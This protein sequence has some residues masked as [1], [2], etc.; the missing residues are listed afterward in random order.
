MLLAEKKKQKNISEYIIFMYQTEDLVRVYNF[1]I[2]L[3]KRY[4]INHFPVSDEEKKKNLDWYQEILIRMEYEGIVSKG[5]LEE[6]QNV[7][8]QLSFLS[9]RLL[10]EDSEYQKVYAPAKKYIDEQIEKYKGEDVNDIE[11]CLN[12]IYGYLLMRMNDEQVDENLMKPL[13]AF[14]DLLSYLSYMYK[15]L[16]IK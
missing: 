3:I 14:G 7:V 10:K 6:V 15:L 11:I 16:N 9:E 4:V 5:H 12:G 8:D 1:D 13:N 2:D